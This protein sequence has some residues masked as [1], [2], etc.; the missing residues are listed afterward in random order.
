MPSPRACGPGEAGFSGGSS[1]SQT[2]PSGRQSSRVCPPDPAKARSSSFMPSPRRSGLTTGGPP[3]SRQR[4]RRSPALPRSQVTST[5]PPCALR[6]PYLA[7]FV[8]S[9]WMAIATAS[10]SAG[11]KAMLG[12][13]AWARSTSPS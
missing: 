2:S 6:A 11:E 12:P 1:N 4:M 13:S 8:A 9:S 5:R 3:S 7:A 10:A